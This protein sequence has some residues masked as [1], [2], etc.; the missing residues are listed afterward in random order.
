M[1]NKMENVIDEELIDNVVATIEEETI[2]E[3]ENAKKRIFHR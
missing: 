1:E 3:G 2:G